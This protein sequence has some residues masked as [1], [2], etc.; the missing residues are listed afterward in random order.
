MVIVCP[1]TYPAAL[2]EQYKP[3][4]ET[5]S[6]ELSPFQK[7]SIQAIVDGH[8]TLVTAHTGSGKTLPIEFA[9]DHFVRKGGKR[10][11]YLGPLKS[12]VDQKYYDFSHKYP[13]ITFG[14]M[15]SD[16]KYQPNA[17]VL[18]MTT[19]IF[20]NYLFTKESGP[21]PS[22]IPTNKTLSFEMDIDH[23]L[24]CV[25]FD[26]VHFILD[27]HRGHVWE[28]TI[29]MLP[30]PIQLIML[31]ATLQDP[32]KL[33]QFVENRKQPASLERKHVVLS[34]TSKRI[35]PLHHYAYM[36]TTES[37][38][39]KVKDK[40]T[41][42]MVRGATNQLLLLKTE[43]GVFQETTYHSVKKVQQLLET[44]QV[45]IKRAHVLN[46]LAKHLCDHDMLPA[47]VFSFSRK[48]VE[49]C[50]HEMT[51]NLLEFDSK[52]PYTARR[53]AE[54]VIRKLPNYQEYMGLPE[55]EALVQLLEKGIAIH[56]SGMIPILREIVELF[57]ERKMVKLL[58]ATDSFSV[59]L[60][61]AIKTTVF[62]AMRKFDG[63]NEQYL[64][65]HLYSQCAGRAG[66]RGMDTVGH[67]VHC[68][69]LFELPSPTEYKEILCGKP[70]KMESKFRISYDVILN[71]MKH[72]KSNKFHRFVNTSM[73]YQEL[74]DQVQGMVVK[75][76]EMSA[77]LN[78]NLFFM[79]NHLQTPVDILQEY[80]QLKESVKVSTNKKRKDAYRRIQNIDDTYK[81]ATFARD[82]EHYEHTKII[83]ESVEKQEHDLVQITTFIK[84]QVQHIVDVLVLR[85]M[86]TVEDPESGH[87]FTQ[88]GRMASNLCEIHPLV[89]VEWMTQ[90]DMCE[91]F[92]VKELIGLLACFT[93]VRV[94]ETHRMTAP[95]SEWSQNIRTSLKVLRRLYHEY[96]DME[97]ERRLCSGYEYQCPIVYDVVEEMMNWS[98]LEN[99]ESC[100]RLLQ[101]DVLG[102]K[103]ISVGDFS[104]AVLKIC[105]IAKEWM[106]VCEQEGFVSLMH[107]LSQ[108]EGRM[109]KYICTN[110]SLYV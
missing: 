6:Y 88:L 90:Q 5:M 16:I 44:Q 86:I 75:L 22:P 87:A 107:K 110:Q 64:P 58:F 8:H 106:N 33:A 9:I 92:S 67:V 104:K 108:I 7:Q 27:E 41:Q 19:E 83:Q 99:Q 48:Q 14:I 21:S 69:N 97:S 70:Q 40:E 73:L 20:M 89:F 38:F 17:Q 68:N 36:I 82:L 4:F 61:C 84:T 101:T 65:P 94:K 2:D 100:K 91:N 63:S 43:E 1:E 46:T 39:K 96:D 57:I 34:S 28:K 3:Y 72:G 26:E 30:S 18:I 42:I 81:C 77:L 76:N 15:T 93:D 54:Q 52:I 49:A 98:E 51:T 59:G 11:V 12:L 31:S 103:G 71:L 105:V 35:V 24:A 13:D 10:M 79:E 53:T 66:R 32:N 62:T 25:V 29:L 55:Y 74:H 56:H 50:A 45:Y 47:I 60:N 78:S 37:L 109:L 85:G 102:A 95:S 80:V 23:E